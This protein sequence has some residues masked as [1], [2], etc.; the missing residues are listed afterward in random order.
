MRKI[1]IA[2]AALLLLCGCEKG[3][4]ISSDTLET[5]VQTV[6]AAEVTTTSETTVT[7][8][9]TTTVTTSETE[10]ASPFKNSEFYQYMQ[11]WQGRFFYD[12]S[13]C[14]LDL[15]GHYELLLRADDGRSFNT[16]IY[17]VYKLN[18]TEPK[19]YGYISLENSK[20]RYTEHTA[21]EGK[22]YRYYDKEQG[23]YKIIG[24]ETKWDDGSFGNV[25]YYVIEN[26]L[27]SD[28]IAR[29]TLSEFSGTPCVPAKYI[30]EEQTTDFSYIDVWNFVY[31]NSTIDLN[32]TEKFLNMPDILQ[33]YEFIDTI[34]LN[35]LEKYKDIDKIMEL[36]C[37]YSEY[38][39]TNEVS[40]PDDDNG[41]IGIVGMGNHK[42]YTSDTKVHIEIR[43]INEFDWNKICEIEDLHSFVLN[44][45]GEDEIDLDLSPLKKYN[46]LTLISLYGNISENTKRQISEFT[47][48]EYVDKWDILIS[49]EED[50]EYVKN[51]PKLRY[52]AVV[53]NND[54]PDYFKFLYD[55]K[56]IK[57]IR[58]DSSVTDEQIKRTIDNMPNVEAVTFGFSEV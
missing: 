39:N 14:D 15:D 5:T 32:G 21:L 27:Y 50:F 40:A 35:D 6:T 33:E 42:I 18:D 28:K 47:N 55:N 52:I 9:E 51:L 53:S 8:V 1:F 43:D 17:K 11:E 7:T 4:E 56:S 10:A 29:K 2:M 57:W 41:Y 16:D 36:V 34:D 58:F 31:C 44:Y 38:E 24:D 49:S 46:N 26:T 3:A 25:Q 54:D 48:L 45:F 23:V 22:L 12:A 13:F 30:R 19:L 37:E 20:S